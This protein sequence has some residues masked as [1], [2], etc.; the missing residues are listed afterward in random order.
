MSKLMLIQ[1]TKIN[2]QSVS[3]FNSYRVVNIKCLKIFKNCEQVQSNLVICSENLLPIFGSNL[4]HSFIVYGKKMFLK[5]SVL[6]SATS[7]A[8]HTQ[9][10][11]S[12]MEKNVVPNFTKNPSWTLHKIYKYEGFLY[13]PFS[14]ICRKS[15]EVY[16]K[17][18]IRKSLYIGIFYPIWRI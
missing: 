1:I 11:A 13:D 10:F 6:N 5:I 18:P 14:R 2:S 15:K 9:N 16:G 4:F 12:T 7:L 3:E 8:L 17:I